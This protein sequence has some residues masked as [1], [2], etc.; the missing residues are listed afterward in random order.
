MP[1]VRE[2][3][4]HLSKISLTPHYADRA[5]FHAVRVRSAASANR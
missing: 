4:R 1:C 3:R 2:R 5:R